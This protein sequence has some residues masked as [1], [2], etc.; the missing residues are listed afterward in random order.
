[1]FR[2]ETFKEMFVCVTNFQCNFFLW[3]KW[4]LQLLK[5][6]KLQWMHVVLF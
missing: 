5:V 6:L 3:K 1:M 4:D 2:K